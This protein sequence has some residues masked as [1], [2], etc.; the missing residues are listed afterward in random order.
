MCELSSKEEC[1]VAMISASTFSFAF[2]VSELYFW[3]YV[4]VHVCAI[5]Y[6]S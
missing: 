5:F 6:N 2:L 3:R 1:L 4:D